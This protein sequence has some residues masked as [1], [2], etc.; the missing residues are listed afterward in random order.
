MR[1]KRIEFR[2]T[3]QICGER[4]AV[5]ADQTGM[6]TG[7][8]GFFRKDGD[9]F[10]AYVFLYALERSIVEGMRTD[11]LYLGPLRVSQALSVLAM[12]G[13]VIIWIARRQKR[14]IIGE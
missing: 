8:S 4:S 10:L 9:V 14:K 11:S 1:R 5:L 12:L 6:M 2:G 3:E 13:V 7:C